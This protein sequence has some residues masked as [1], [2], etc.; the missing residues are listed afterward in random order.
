MMKKM[1]HIKNVMKNVQN[2]QQEV[3]KQ[4]IIVNNVLKVIILYIQN[5]EI[6]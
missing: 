2:V 4:I 3:L 5:L 1:I 6:V